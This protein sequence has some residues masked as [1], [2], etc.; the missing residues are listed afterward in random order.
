[1]ADP[2]PAALSHLFH[3]KIDMV[4]IGLWSE[5]TGLS[6]AYDVKE[7]EEGG[8]N[9]YVY[10]LPGRLTYENITLKRPLDKES[11]KLH[12]WFA[13]LMGNSAVRTTASVTVYDSDLAAV[14][15]WNF[16]DVIPVSWTGPDFNAGDEQVAMESVEFA[17]HGFTRTAS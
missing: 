10:K 2:T 6:A 7:Y 16:I 11:D 17:H 14:A 9:F 4:D 12:G 13:S 1:M 15:T 5:F 8:N 3:A